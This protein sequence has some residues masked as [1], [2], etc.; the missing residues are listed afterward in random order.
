[1][2]LWSLNNYIIPNF[3]FFPNVCSPCLTLYFPPT[4]RHI[5]FLPLSLMT[6]RSPFV[7]LSEVSQN[8]W[9]CLSCQLLKDCFGGHRTVIESVARK[10]N[11]PTGNFTLEESRG[12]L[13]KNSNTH[14]A[15][16]LGL[17]NTRLTLARYITCQGWHQCVLGQPGRKKL[18][19]TFLNPSMALDGE[20]FICL[21]DDV[22]SVG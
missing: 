12:Q 17:H 18:S 6:Y 1:M 8:S 2:A 19:S 7:V 3:L 22:P 16:A 20:V 13:C 14:H 11:G 21:E 5:L 15:S 4:P 10:T 9:L